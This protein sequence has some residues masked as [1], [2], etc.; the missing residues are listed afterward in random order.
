MRDYPENCVASPP[1]SAKHCII[2]PVRRA[3]VP[4]M[5]T[6][7]C[8]VVSRYTYMPR[9][10]WSN[11]ITGTVPTPLLTHLPEHY[12]LLVYFWSPLPETTSS[13]LLHCMLLFPSSS[14]QIVVDLVRCQAERE[15]T[16]A[17]QA[18]QHEVEEA[19]QTQRVADEYT[20]TA[21][22]LRASEL[23]DR[24][25]RTPSGS[26]VRPKTPHDLPLGAVLGVEGR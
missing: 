12:T 6:G 1:V 2:V 15:L 25:E 22:N 3:V 24:S 7:V 20:K 4:R 10:S 26:P 16:L 17:E 8:E 5:N 19:T 21:R 11:R 13:R 18:L 23:P 14:Q 9:H